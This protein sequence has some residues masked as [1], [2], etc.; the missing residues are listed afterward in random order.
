MHIAKIL[1]LLMM[2]C[3]PWAVHAQGK[4]V[5]HLAQIQA[6]KAVRVC[7]WPDYYSI[8]YQ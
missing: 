8:T 4:T 1:L 5:S 6:A 7:I 2:A 3:L